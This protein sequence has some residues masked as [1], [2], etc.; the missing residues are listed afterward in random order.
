[1]RK[2]LEQARQQADEQRSQWTQ[3]ELQL[4]GE[5]EDQER[6]ARELE[7]QLA[8]ALQ[9]NEQVS[10]ASLIPRLFVVASDVKAY[11]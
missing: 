3:R 1:M 2:E 4:Q 9:E 8:T 11:V 10:T 6:Q 5:R 7:G